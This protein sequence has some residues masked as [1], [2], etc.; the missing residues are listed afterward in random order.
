MIRAASAVCALVVT[1]GLASAQVTLFSSTL[2]GANEVPAVAT[3]ATGLLLGSYNASTNSF[4]FN[5]SISGLIG[6]PTVSH[7]HE[8]PVGVNG[9][10]RFGFNSP[11]PTYPLIGSATWT[12]LTPTQV[13]T[14]FNGGFYVNF[15]TSTFG[16]G[17]VRGQITVIPAPGA[18]GLL[19]LAGLC[20]TRRRR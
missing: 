16:P 8:A 15:H 6:N 14:L 9:P 4:S 13:T 10:V 3:P 20:A 1:A 17:E 11:G 12:G 2:S 7:I 18:V 5:W 19:A